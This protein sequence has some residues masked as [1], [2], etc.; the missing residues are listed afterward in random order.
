M[1]YVTLPSRLE[2]S[3]HAGQTSFTEQFVDP[4]M[5]DSW[6]SGLKDAD[7][8]F[9]GDAALRVRTRYPGDRRPGVDHLEITLSK[10][11]QIA[12]MAASADLPIWAVG[13]VTRTPAT[14]GT[15]LSS[16]LSA[17]QQQVWA[18]RLDRASAVVQASG[19]LE[20]DSDW[21]GGLVVMLPA[22]ADDFATLS[23]TDSADTGAVTTC[24]S[25]TPRILINPG[26]FAA[27]AR[28]LQSTVIHEA[29]HVATDSPCKSGTEWVVEGVA[30]SVS[31]A[32]DPTTASSNRELVR[33]YLR[34]NGVPAALPQRVESSTDY[35]LAQVAVDQVRARLGA[36]EAADFLVRGVAGRLSDAEVAR[37][38]QWYRA[39]LQ[40]RAG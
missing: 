34:A 10:D 40:R 31:A 25:G 35:A 21:N 32:S 37:A 22:N 19:V 1:Q 15:V 24:A 5:A 26:S 16:G 6:Y 17:A 13:P 11:G 28:W 3:L 36:Q 18:T 7:T 23:G 4:T 2:Q 8:H 9:T 29:V 38:T 14:H 39:E 12:D 33:S 30:E 27:G 20:P